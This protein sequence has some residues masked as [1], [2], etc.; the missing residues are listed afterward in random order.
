MKNIL[1]ALCVAMSLVA[2]ADYNVRDYGAKGDGTTKDTAA[3]QKAID[4]AEKAGGGEVFLPPGTYL[5]GTIYLKDNVDFHIGPGA[6]VMASPDKADYNAADVCQQNGR[7]YAP[8]STS[9]QHLFLAIEKKNV[10]MRGPGTVDGN[11]AVFLINPKTNLPW[12]E[13]IRDK[14]DPFWRNQA[15]I[16]FRP[17]QMLCFYE[18][19]NVHLT[20]LELKDSHYWN[21]FLHGCEHVF[22]RGLYIHN[23]KKK[24]HT[25]NGDGIDID[26]SRY[27]T[28]SDCC[29]DTADDC[30]TLRASGLDRLKHPG[31]CA[32][33]TIA[34]CTL[35]SPCNA[36]RV[37]V[38][39]GKIHDCVVTGMTVHDA[40]TAV[41]FVSAWNPKQSDGCDIS[42]LRIS[43]WTVDCK[44]LFHVYGGPLAKDVKRTATTHDIVIS[45]M[46]GRVSGTSSIEGCS[47]DCPI[48]NVVLKDLD[49][50]CEVSVKFAENVRTEGGKVR[51][52]K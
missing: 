25:H 44:H 19:N 26:C 15:C 1:V 21:V 11:S 22:V 16:P 39:N 51:L 31:D 32:Y 17:S 13:D 45:G 12:G 9:G 24:F 2:A 7:G 18:C 35:S 46:S 36:I 43:N 6:V 23:E 38:G 28:V 52:V 40:R 10:T 14:N 37:G 34:N 47:E 8:E 5:C 3:V 49:I 48:R 27:V 20:D 29:I 4:A 33:V 50:D 30:L 41:N 42:N